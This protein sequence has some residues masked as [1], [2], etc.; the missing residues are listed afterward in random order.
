MEVDWADTLPDRAGENVTFADL[1]LAPFAARMYI[2]AEHRELS[3]DLLNKN[4]KSE[5]AEM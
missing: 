2:L 5:R 1:V 4:F 3:D